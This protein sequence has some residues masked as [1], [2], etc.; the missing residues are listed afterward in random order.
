[1]ATETQLAAMA[2][3]ASATDATKETK[4][5]LSPYFNASNDI[6]A[7]ITN[8]LA[9][10][11]G[12]KDARPGILEKWLVEEPEGEVRSAVESVLS[13]LIDGIVAYRDTPRDPSEAPG[14]HYVGIDA[15]GN[16]HHFK[17]SSTPTEKSASCVNFK[18]VLGA[19]ST[20][21]GAEY[22]VR[23][24]RKAADTLVFHRAGTAK[25]LGARAD[26]AKQVN[27]Q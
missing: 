15:E 5:R 16:L 24:G 3:D 10:A 2:A 8:K 12:E 9:L 27:G 23:K 14:R 4:V 25:D 6:L 18:I 19:F 17:S 1:M 7:M 21:G 11:A 13:T 20:F 22:C 26:Y